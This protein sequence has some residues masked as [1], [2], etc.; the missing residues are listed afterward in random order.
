MDAQLTIDDRL[1]EQLKASGEIQVKESHGVEVIV[2]TIDAR[3]KLQ[4]AVYDQSKWDDGDWSEGEMMSVLAE[5][6]SDK[7]HWGHPDMDVYDKQYGHLFDD[8]HGSDS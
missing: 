3:Q 8:D 4:T 6:L 1:F 7:E 5:Q 2:M